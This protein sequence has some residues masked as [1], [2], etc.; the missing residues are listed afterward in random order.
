MKLGQFC[1]PFKDAMLDFLLQIYLDTEKE[2]SEDYHEPLWRSSIVSSMT[3]R[4]SS[5]CASTFLRGP[6][7]ANKGKVRPTSLT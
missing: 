1:Y 7:S 6:P 5:R 2:I 4:N 3:L